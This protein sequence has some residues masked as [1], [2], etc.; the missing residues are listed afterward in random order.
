MSKASLCAGEV[1]SNTAQTKMKIVYNIV[2]LVS[3]I[4]QI[5]DSPKGRMMMAV[6]EGMAEFYSQNLAREV[7]KGMH[8]NALKCI[9]TGGRPPLGYDVHPETRK[10][11]L[12]QAESETV[13][14]IFDRALERTAYGEIV[15]ELTM[16]DSVDM[17]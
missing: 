6:L 1:V 2:Q 12:N 15:N 4:E 5:D 16:L 8:E 9:H 14:L 13:R 11:V 7:R 3:V 10:L 17:S